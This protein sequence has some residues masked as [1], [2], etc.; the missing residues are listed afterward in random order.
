MFWIKVF[1]LPFAA[2]LVGS[3]PWGML[4]TRLFSSV[5]VTKEGS[6]NIGATNVKRTAGWPLGLLTLAGDMAKGALP[7]A[8]AKGLMETSGAWGDAYVAVVVL[9]TVSG[10]LFPVYTRFKKGGKGVATAAGCFGALSIVS[11][12]ILLMVFVMM[13]CYFNRVSLASLSALLAAPAV[14]WQATASPALTASAFIL[15]F[16]ISFRH[17]A[18]IRRLLQGMEP[19]FF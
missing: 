18:N 17:K 10:H 1:L 9:V 12:L 8:L 2:F 15:A 14:L 6:G 11:L 5:D 16:I 19:P 7:T 3:I 13:L 4:L